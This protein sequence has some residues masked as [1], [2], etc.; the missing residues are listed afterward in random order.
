MKQMFALHF[1][2][3]LV[4][5]AAPATAGLPREAGAVVANGKSAY[6]IVIPHQSTPVER[7]AAGELARYV[8]Q[9]SDVALP[10]VDDIAPER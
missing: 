10:V 1:G 5:T 9:M 2:L 6:Q 4:L 3:V 8:R 7:K